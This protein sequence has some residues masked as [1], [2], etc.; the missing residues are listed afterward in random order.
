MPDIVIKKQLTEIF[1]LF[2]EF[3]D[4]NRLASAPYICNMSDPFEETSPIYVKDLNKVLSFFTY[5][6]DVD[7]YYDKKN[8]EGLLYPYRELSYPDI[9]TQVRLALRDYDVVDWREEL[10]EDDTVIEWHGNR[11]ENDTCAKVYERA[12]TDEDDLMVHATLFVFP[13][14]IDDGSERFVFRKD[15]IKCFLPYHTTLK[16]LHTWLS[17]NRIPK[18]QFRYCDKHG[19]N[20]IG[21][22]LLPDGTHTALLDCSREHAQDILHKA[23]GVISV[24]RDLWYY[25]AEYGKVLYFEYQNDNP[26]NEFHGY[27]LSQGDKGYEK[28]NLSLLRQ[29]QDDIPSI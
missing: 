5:E 12:H 29:I 14:A 8:L 7:R 20:G 10:G 1:F 16:G 18:R 9:E 11:V 24:D 23:I 26:Q 4:V 25:D 28:V 2:P 17:E 15:N 6:K 13:N 3:I 22:R 19:E 21:G 27:H